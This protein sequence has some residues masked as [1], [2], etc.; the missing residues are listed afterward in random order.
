MEIF[1]KKHLITPYWTA[2]NKLIS[3]EFLEPNKTVID[4]GC[5]ERDLLKYYSSSKYLGIDV[6]DS[7]DI[8]LNLNSRYTLDPGW[9]YAVNSGILEFLDNFENHF[10]NLKG[11][12]TEYIF[13]WWSGYG[14]GNLPHSKFEKILS[15]YYRIDKEINWG[16]VQ[17]LY[18]CSDISC[19]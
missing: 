1:A 9:D 18:K 13:T 8:I 12:A 2:R 10:L 6:I 4:F 7:A 5:G 19:T 15:K 14:Y 3:T 17:K 16:P 11:L